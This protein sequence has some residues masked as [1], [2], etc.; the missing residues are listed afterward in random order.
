[1]VAIP[2][3]LTLLYR[4][5]A[6]RP[7]ST[8]MLADLARLEKF[9]RDWVEFD[10]IA[11]MLVKSVVVSEDG[12]FCRH[13]GIDWAELNA[14]IED[15]LDGEPTRGASTI[16]MQTTKNLFLWPGRSLVR[17]AVEMPLA[18]W[19]DFVLPKKRIME[20]YLNIAEWGDGIYGIEA[21]SWT[22]FGRPALD[23]TD[24]QAA[25]MAVTLPNPY[26]RNPA[27]PT[28]HLNRLANVIEARARRAGPFVTCLY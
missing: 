22:H 15:A 28:T 21:A 6:I 4:I 1:M 12:K 20:I 2:L 13:Y 11:P 3:I 9:E 7:V 27:A 25:L 10:D 16:T 17:K 14:V 23:L 8:L 19:V 5:D 26:Q 24:R 18:I